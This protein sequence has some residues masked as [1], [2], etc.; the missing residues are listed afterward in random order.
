[1]DTN[2]VLLVIC[3]VLTGIWIVYTRTLHNTIS[4][5]RLDLHETHA[6]LCDALMEDEAYTYAGDGDEEYCT[7]T[8]NG[9]A[10]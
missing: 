8:K 2:T 1:M 7:Y 10:K 3:A 9:V 6:L 4:E 5:M